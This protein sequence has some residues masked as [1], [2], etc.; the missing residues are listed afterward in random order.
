MG[1]R[2]RP[3]T[4]LNQAP[5]RSLQAYHYL[6]GVALEAPGEPHHHRMRVDARVRRPGAGVRNVMQAVVDLDRSSFGDSE[7]HPGANE[8]R[9]VEARLAR[10]N[11]ARR[12]QRSCT[13]P[14]H[15][16]DTACRPQAMFVHEAPSRAPGA[17]RLIEV[18]EWR[19]L[20]ADCRLPPKN[21]LVLASTS[22]PPST[23]VHRTHTESMSISFEPL[24]CAPIPWLPATAQRLCPGR[25]ACTS[26]VREAGSGNSRGGAVSWASTGVARLKMAKMSELHRSIVNS[27]VSGCAALTSATASWRFDPTVSHARWTGAFR[28]R[29]ARV[30]DSHCTSPET[31]AAVSATPERV[32]AM[33]R[34]AW[35][36]ASHCG[37][38]VD[39]EGVER[40][41]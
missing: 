14:D 32:A 19:E 11:P 12:E 17:R 3:P 15:R 28:G 26:S 23:R 21:F 22:W 13:S 10:G 7:L 16:A 39:L 4:R 37:R 30:L 33:Q 31:A 6:W 18:A 36:A 40:S 1:S 35:L 25:L 8:E 20:D 5:S 27:R 41:S 29:P 24:I 38:D 9:V 34:V 2:R